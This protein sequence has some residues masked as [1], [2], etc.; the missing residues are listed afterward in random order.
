MDKKNRKHLQDGIK[1]EN[2]D[3]TMGGKLYDK[4]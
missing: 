4:N 2:L 3:V 1:L